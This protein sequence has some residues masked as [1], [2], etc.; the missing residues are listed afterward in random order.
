[1]GKN[2][3]QKNSIRIEWIDSLKGIGIFLVVLGH[4]TID[5][6]AFSYIF[7]FHMPLFF[8]ISGYLFDFN[9][10]KS[11]K[12][13]A[14]TK[15]KSILWPY[16][17]FS[18]IS[19]LIII[20]LDSQNIQHIQNYIR[21]FILAKRNN[22]PYNGALWFLAALF[23]TEMMY[24]LLMQYVK[25]DCMISFILIVSSYIAIIQFGALWSANTMPWSFDTCMVYILF[26]HIGYIFK[27]MKINNLTNYII[28]TFGIVFSIILFIDREFFYAMFFPH[29][30]DVYIDI[31]VYISEITIALMGIFT[32]TALAKIICNLKFIN[33]IGK[34]S[35]VVFA[36]HLPIAIILS[37]RVMEVCNIK[38]TNISFN[39][40][41]ETIF[42]III[43]IP[44]IECIN[45]LFPW[46]IGKR[47]KITN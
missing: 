19:I 27:G 39:G 32:Y 9:K 11:F 22:I 1:M 14:K 37:R 17:I 7:S 47:K 33:Y 21:D 23:V 35:I 10:Y 42:A 38:F 25:K 15:F 24:F 34:N 3:L 44:F 43:M 20:A 5:N 16:I 45:R 30:G 13:F 46:I 28:L 36:L 2:N 41:L 31:M 18:I 29:L 26:Y 8:F 12:K 4:A 40:L 6:K